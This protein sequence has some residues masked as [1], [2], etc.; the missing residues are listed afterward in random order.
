MSQLFHSSSGDQIAASTVVS[1]L[2]A[3][4]RERPLSDYRI[5]IGTDSQLLQNGVADFVS[6]IVIH[7]VGNGGRYFFRRF[8]EKNFFTLRDRIIHEV[9]VSLDLGTQIL[10]PLR[11]HPHLQFEFEI[12]ADVGENGPTKAMLQEVIGMIRAYN[13]EAKVKPESY[14][15]SSIAD[16][17]V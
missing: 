10:E 17:H 16:R 6:A 15:A 5:T 1:E 11:Q 14:A 3:Y 13:F 9:L 12:H 7:R 4:M 8:N 2:V